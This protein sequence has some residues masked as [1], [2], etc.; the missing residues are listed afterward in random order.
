M[1]SLDN[2]PPVND[3]APTS[4]YS[5][6]VLY[7]FSGTLYT[8]AFGG[9]IDSNGNL[10]GIA[11]GGGTYGAGTIFKVSSKYLALYPRVR[12]M[13]L[14]HCKRLLHARI[15]KKFHANLALDRPSHHTLQIGPP[16]Y[17]FRRDPNL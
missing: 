12:S 10:Y 1:H 14:P 2:F 11:R 5:E 15:G 6:S 9:I 13:L 3:A 16:G 4:G 17:L 8:P 7:N